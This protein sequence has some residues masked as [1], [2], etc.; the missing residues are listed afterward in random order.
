MHTKD[1]EKK[2]FQTRLFELLQGSNCK[3]TPITNELSPLLAP[4]SACAGLSLKHSPDL[5][6]YNVL[7]KAS[8]RSHFLLPVS[9]FKIELKV[10]SE[11]FSVQEI[12]FA[13]DSLQSWEF[14]FNVVL[15]ESDPPRKLQCDQISIYFTP[16][17]YVNVPYEG[18]CYCYTLS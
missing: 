11:I 3:F 16:D 5:N 6:S 1:E 14:E 2:L 15:S 8:L 17:F 4:F 9:I 7:F 10:C 18:S 13:V 12:N